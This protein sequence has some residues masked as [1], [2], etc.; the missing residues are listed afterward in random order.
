MSQSL[1][2]ADV[3]DLYVSVRILSNSFCIVKELTQNINTI[4]IFDTKCRVFQMLLLL[5]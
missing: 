4:I 1:M 3:S 5:S 2:Q